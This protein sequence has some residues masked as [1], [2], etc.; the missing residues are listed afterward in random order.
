MIITKR[1]RKSSTIIFPPDLVFPFWYVY[2]NFNETDLDESDNS[3][4]E[5]DLFGCYIVRSCSKYL[6]FSIAKKE[7]KKQLEQEE[8]EKEW[9]QQGQ[10]RGRSSSVG[11]CGRRVVNRCGRSSWSRSS[12]NVVRQ[13]IMGTTAFF[14]TPNIDDGGCY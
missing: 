7:N 9:G 1:K 11:S 8:Q 3:I 10:D 5:R 14:N 13:T 2:I 4:F 12:N 6:S